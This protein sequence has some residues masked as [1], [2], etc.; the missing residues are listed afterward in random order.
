VTLASGRLFD[1]V[2][3]FAEEL[4]ICE[5]L[6]CNQ[7]AVVKDLPAG[8]ALYNCSVPRPLANEFMA[9]VLQQGWDL[10]VYAGDRLYAHEVTPEVRLL[11]DLAPRGQ[12]VHAL[13][14]LDSRVE[15]EQLLVIVQPERT[16]L[17]ERLLK[18]RFGGRL[19]IVRSFSHFV[20][21]SNLL[22]SKGRALAF[23][24]DR[25]GIG[26]AETM[27]IGD[28]DNDASM[29]DWAGMGIAV[30]NASA[31]VKAV[32]N[33]VTGTVTEDGAA[34]AIER[35]ILGTNHG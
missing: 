31:A 25:L 33:Y 24:A 19:C 35:F 5:P 23:L 32:A 29:V 11:V 13:E 22:V 8:R 3:V 12:K 1:Q 18:E 17:V 30:G 21:G 16:A 4:G 28:Q 7:G 20:E 26:Q 27:A 9:Y 6:I 14:E 34:Q 2:R 10:C 15:L